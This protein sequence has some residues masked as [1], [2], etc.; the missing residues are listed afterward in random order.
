MT[1]CDVLR[2]VCL[3]WLGVGLA[4]AGAHAWTLLPPLLAYVVL[5]GDGALRP[6]SG[7]LLPVIRHGNRHNSSVALS[8][9][10]GPDALLTPLVL[11]AL[12]RHQARATFFVIGRHAEAHPELIRRL[13]SA[14]HE[15]ANHSYSHS[16]FLNLRFRQAMRADISRGVKTLERLCPAVSPTLYRPPMGLKNPTLARLQQQLGLRVVMW[17]LHA[18]DTRKRSAEEIAMHVLRRIRGGDIVIFHDGHDLPGKHRDTALAGAL[19]RI[20][21]AL[22]QRGLKPVT[23]S[24]LIGGPA[25]PAPGIPH[26]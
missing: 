12:Q 8:F 14:G 2:A 22:A 16:R 5:A 7:W 3:L 24:E 15:I 9:D 6:G 13:A 10:D 18:G 4:V 20:L 19:D 25:V 21:P 17:S 1:R 26:L 23:V 11:A